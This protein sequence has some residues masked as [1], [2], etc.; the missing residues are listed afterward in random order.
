M[1]A[2]ASPAFCKPATCFQNDVLFAAR[3]AQAKGLNNSDSQVVGMS[4][5]RAVVADDWQ[6][7]AEKAVSQS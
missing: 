7:K 4:L 2:A 5:A 3:F 6:R 1:T